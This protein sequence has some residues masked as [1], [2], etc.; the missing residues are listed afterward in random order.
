[1][2][3]SIMAIS[4]DHVAEFSPGRGHAREFFADAMKPPPTAAIP[5]RAGRRPVFATALEAWR[6]LFGNVEAILRL[7]LSFK[8][9]TA[10]RTLLGPRII[11]GHVAELDSPTNP[12]F[13]SGGTA[14]M[15]IRHRRIARFTACVLVG[16]FTASDA[17][18][19]SDGYIF[20]AGDGR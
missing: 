15:T 18:K 12:D 17:G 9:F 6:T 5:F 10:A 14:G 8:R 1:M 11:G 20:N 19:G 13:V 16:M 3:T 7:T 4:V 2:R